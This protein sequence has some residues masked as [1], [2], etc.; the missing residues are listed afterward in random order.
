M[1]SICCIGLYIL[2]NIGDGTINVKHS[3][4]IIGEPIQKM[5]EDNLFPSQ[6]II[7][8]NLVPCPWCKQTPIFRQTTCRQNYDSTGKYYNDMIDLPQETVQCVNSRC[9]C[10][11]RINRVGTTDVI[12]LWNACASNKPEVIK[13]GDRV[14]VVCD[15]HPLNDWHGNLKIIEDH[16]GLVDI[17]GYVFNI[18][19]SNLKKD[20]YE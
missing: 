4:N 8:D 12:E 10:R 19:M 18:Q 6:K 5:R 3:W 7:E 15:G 2:I 1:I 17:E 14:R 13:E 9:A 20:K 16:V 11:P